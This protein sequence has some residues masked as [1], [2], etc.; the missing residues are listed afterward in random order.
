[1]R[2]YAFS[3]V[4]CDNKKSRQR[5]F[6]FMHYCNLMCYAIPPHC[7]SS[8]GRA[9]M[10]IPWCLF[11]KVHCY[12]CIPSQIL[13]FTV[14]DLKL[15]WGNWRN[16]IVA[17]SF[18]SFSRAI[19]WRKMQ[20]CNHVII[21]NHL[22]LFLFLLLFEFIITQFVK[23]IFLLWWFICGD[24]NKYFPHF[25]TQKALCLQTDNSTKS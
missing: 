19:K 13:L 18:V 11:K 1:M 25:S 16:T 4:I 5:L 17:K 10:T 2:V 3:S 23:S 21:H 7:F 22:W 14:G 24:I 6:M 8:L 12:K 9:L 15:L 20:L